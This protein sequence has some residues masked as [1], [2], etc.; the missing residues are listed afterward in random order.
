MKIFIVTNHVPC[1]Q[2][3]LYL[4]HQTWAFKQIF[5]LLLLY[6][7]YYYRKTM[8]LSIIIN[9]CSCY[10]NMWLLLSSCAPLFLPVASAA[11]LLA[12]AGARRK[13]SEECSWSSAAV[14]APYPA[15][16]ARTLASRNAPP[17]AG[18]LYSPWR[19]KKSLLKR[20]GRRRKL[21]HP[22]AFVRFLRIVKGRREGWNYS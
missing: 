6:Y 7:Y 17:D 8:L 13:R 18:P 5:L 10:I 3:N 21:A 14:S 15:P 22:S 2:V 11:P 9:H 16:L 1:E 19:L 12:R 20:L 4:L